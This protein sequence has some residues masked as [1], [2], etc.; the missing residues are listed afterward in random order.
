VLAAAAALLL[1]GPAWA[2]V[3]TGVY[4]EGQVGYSFPDS[5]DASAGGV[6]GDVDLEEAPV[7]G[8]AVGYR[9]THARLELNGSYRKYDVDEVNAQGLSSSGEGDAT[10]AVALVNLFIDPDL[11]YPVH[12]FFGG[13]VGAAYVAVDTG[14]DSPLEIDDEAGAFAWNLSAGLTWDV[15]PNVALSASYRYLRLAGTDFSADL[16]GVDVGDVDVDDV[17]SHEVLVGLRYTF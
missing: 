6:D 13:G 4:L 11:G 7:F 9:F 17:N 2:E 1:S 8:G 10:S 5:V 16:A 3:N 15:T 14:D 12:P